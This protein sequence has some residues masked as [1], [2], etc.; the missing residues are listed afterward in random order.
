MMPRQPASKP[1]AKSGGV[2]LGDE[3]ESVRSADL[4]SCQKRFFVERFKKNKISKEIR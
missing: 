3:S 4:F 1:G 2:I